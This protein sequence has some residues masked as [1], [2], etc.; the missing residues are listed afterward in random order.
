MD[1]FSRKLED[2]SGLQS[3]LDCLLG[4]SLA[5][6]GAVRGNVQTMDWAS[7]TL[8][9]GA[10][11]GFTDDFLDAFATV[12]MEDRSSCGRAIRERRQIVIEDVHLDPAFGPYVKL[13]E[14]SGFCAV[15]STPLISHNDA[16]VG[17]V[18]THF[19]V[20]HRPS[21]RTLHEM[22]CAGALCANAIIRDKV[23]RSSPRRTRTWFEMDRRKG[24]KER[25]RASSLA[26]QSDRWSRAYL[27][28]LV[29]IAEGRWHA[30][31]P[32]FPGSDSEAPTPRL[33]LDTATRAAQQLALELIELGHAWSEP[34]S[35]AEIQENPL[36]STSRAIWRKAIISYVSIVF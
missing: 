28:V 32:D 13:A 6:T 25:V 12:G 27:A 18:S 8:R 10:H 4:Y 7:G 5:L 31:L 29:P 11:E 15:Q 19:S 20:P 2:C 34:R 24:E 14:R 36:W 21:E 22:Q 23:E 3:I 17:V 16:L 9:I 26:P 35:I 30:E 1:P 33:A